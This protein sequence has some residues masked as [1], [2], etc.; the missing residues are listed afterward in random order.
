M[1]LYACAYE[2]ILLLL[3]Y[4]KKGGDV[5][6]KE[7]QTY[8]ADG[9]VFPKKITPTDPAL[10]RFTFGFFFSV[11][12]SRLA[13]RSNNNG[14]CKDVTE[15]LATLRIPDDDGTN[16]VDEQAINNAEEV[17]NN[18]PAPANC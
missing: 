16:E 13:T 10:G 1:C 9:R 7:Q 8:K 15:A 5:Q 3:R 11:R 14:V 18:R 4:Y 6:K 17:T 2:H 12:G